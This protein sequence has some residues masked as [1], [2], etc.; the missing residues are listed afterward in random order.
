MPRRFQLARVEL[1]RGEF[2]SNGTYGAGGVG[3]YE[4]ISPIIG[5]KYD[6]RTGESQYVP[7]TWPKNWCRRTP[8]RPRRPSRYLHPGHRGYRRRP[9]RNRKPQRHNSALR[10]VPG[11][12]LRRA[13]LFSPP[14]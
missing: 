12:E 6:D 1:P 13:P 4:S 11:H 9:A 14:P 2:M 3:N 7:E 10:P 5:A 8:D